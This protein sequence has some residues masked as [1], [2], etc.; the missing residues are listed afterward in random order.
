EFI[1]SAYSSSE[2][3]QNSAAATSPKLHRTTP[4]PL[5]RGAHRCAARDEAARINAPGTVT[6]AAP[7]WMPASAL[8]TGTYTLRATDRSASQGFRFVGPDVRRET[9][10][11]FKVGKSWSVKLQRACTHTVL[12]ARSAIRLVVSLSCCASFGSRKRHL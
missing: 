6:L 5:T 10:S 4:M 9:G 3:G 12:A 7:F 11:R 2:P 1:G 8:S